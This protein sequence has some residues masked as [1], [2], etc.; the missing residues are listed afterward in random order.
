MMMVA[1]PMTVGMPMILILVMIV[2]MAVLMIGNGH[3]LSFGIAEHHRFDD[4]AQG[5]FLQSHMG[6]EETGEPG[7]N[8]RLRSQTRIVL[9]IMRAVGI[10]RRA[11]QRV[12][13]KLVHVGVQVVFVFG[14]GRL[15]VLRQEIVR[16]THEPAMQPL[17]DVAWAVFF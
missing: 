9:S 15:G 3:F 8:Q 6:S 17:F 7:E 12:S 16:M 10:T 2:R 13:E 5:I 4:L 14:L 11:R 1:V